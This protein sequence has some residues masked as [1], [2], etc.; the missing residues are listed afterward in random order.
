MCFVDYTD[1]LNDIRSKL[2]QFRTDEAYQYY[3]LN[4]SAFALVKSCEII[5]I[6]KEMIFRAVDQLN[7]GE[8]GY[9]DLAHFLK[10]TLR[11]DDLFVDSIMNT[12]CEDQAKKITADRYTYF[13]RCFMLQTEQDG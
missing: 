3:V 10:E 6:T 2:D 8:V 1:T 4:Y 11:L 12:L 5:G 13:L 9:F 7:K